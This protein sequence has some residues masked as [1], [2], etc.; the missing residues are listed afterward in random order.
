MRQILRYATTKLYPQ[1]L[2]EHMLIIYN[3]SLKSVDN[4]NDLGNNI[5]FLDSYDG[6]ELTSSARNKIIICSYSTQK[7]SIDTINAG[8]STV[9]GMD[10]FNW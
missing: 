8:Y 7:T 3:A 2:Q 5:I 9:R 10:I 1:R 6:A 4:N